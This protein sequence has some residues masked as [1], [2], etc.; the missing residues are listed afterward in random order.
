MTKVRRLVP[1]GSWCITAHQC[2]VN[3]KKFLPEETK[4]GPFDWTIT[5]FR[6]L[7]KVIRE[8]INQNLILNPID[9]YINGLGSVTCSYSG[10]AFH[11]HLS[12]TLVASYGGEKNQN[13]MHTELLESKE[14][15]DAKSRFCHTLGNLVKTS[16]EE[17]NLYVRWVREGIGEKVIN[18][19]EVFNGE[20]PTKTYELLRS[21]GWLNNSGLLYVTTEMVKGVKEPLKNPIKSISKIS[22]SCWNCIIKEREGFNG[23]PAGAIWKGDEMSWQSLFR[24]ILENS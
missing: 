12:R 21:N 18:F 5:P 11:H 15:R 3:S 23:D 13:V 22:D 24:E 14:W 2:R 4:S 16:K 1:L 17:G 9:S 10:I 6:S 8:D 20:D 7:S 19:P